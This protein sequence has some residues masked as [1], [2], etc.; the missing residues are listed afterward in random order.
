MR[1]TLLVLALATACAAAA[2]QKKPEAGAAEA[3]AVDAAAAEATAPD[4]SGDVAA[5]ADGAATAPAPRPV[6]LPM[7]AYAYDFDLKAPAARI[8][9]L[10]RKHE[11]ACIDAGPAT[12]QVI[13]VDMQAEGRDRTRGR[14]EVRATQAWI[15]LIRPGLVMDAQEAGGELVGSEIETDDLTASIVDTEAAIRSKEAMRARL[16]QM[17]A[18]RP[19]KLE[20]A[21]EVERELAR[22]QQEIDAARSGLA[23]M[24]T[25]VATSKLV[26]DYVS[27]GVLAPDSAWRPVQSA[28]QS[29][30]GNVMGVFG[31]LILAAS[32]ILP[33]V[34][35]LGPV[36][37]FLAS[38]RRARRPLPSPEA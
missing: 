4:T 30:L 26:V 13:G 12:C 20:E 2:C 16:Q 5:S 23:V 3:V 32:F 19:G 38:R 22:V 8:P 27:T 34:L 15:R 37:W 35:V 21:L 6:G 25:R 28:A 36:A 17:L 14:L 31:G 1:R 10:M 9:D 7:L 33:L 29:F 11:Q 18:N 24:R